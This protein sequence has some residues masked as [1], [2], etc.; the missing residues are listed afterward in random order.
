MVLEQWSEP[1]E[2][3]GV[4]IVDPEDRVRVAHADD[5]RRVQHRRVDRADLQFDH[6]GVA[7]FLGE[8]N[9][10]PAELR[11]AHVDG[12][13]AIGRAAPA[14][15]QAGA[16]L[17]GQAVLVAA[18]KHLPRDAAHAV[19]A[20]AGFGA[21]IVV[22]P[23][24][25]FGAGQPG[26]L[27]QHQLIVGDMRRHRPRI[28]RRHRRRLIAQVDHHDLV[29]DA[30]HLGEQAVVQRAHALVLAAPI[31]RTRSGLASL[32]P[33]AAHGHR[34]ATPSSHGS[35]GRDEIADRML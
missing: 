31:W 21:V 6:P 26:R 15:E 10:L 27:Q 2:I 4:H 29:A 13:E 7:E 1:A 23:D 30:V 34:E 8:R 12:V 5:R 9:V 22:D 18:G 3:V 32:P 14:I 25:G 19:A 17:E 20:G 16:G 11:L 33:A 24:E 28:G 35:P